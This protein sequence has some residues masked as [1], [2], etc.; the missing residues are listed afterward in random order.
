MATIK[1][2]YIEVW[3]EESTGKHIKRPMVPIE[4]IGP[5]S[6]LPV[7][8]IIDSGADRS[9]FNLEI[10]KEIGLDLS[11]GKKREVIG[12]TGVGEE[13]VVDVEIKIKDLGAYKIPVGFIDSKYVP[14]LL[15][16]EGF[17]DLNKIKFEKDHNIFE[18]TP[19]RKK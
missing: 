15:G 9:L 1:F 5:K 17:F 11:T 14:A 4:I 13:I 7:L 18:V 8:A 12:I 16:E 19:I 10:A 3:G 2:P 6:S